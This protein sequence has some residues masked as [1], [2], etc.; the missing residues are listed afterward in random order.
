MVDEMP[1]CGWQITPVCDAAEWD[2]FSAEVRQAATDYAAMI[3]WAAT[4]RRYGVCETTVRP[5]RRDCEDCADGW[6]W[7]DG[8]WLPYIAN[9]VWRNCWCG[10]G[11][12]CQSCRASCQVWLPGPVFAITNVTIDG[13]TVD[14]ST[15]DLQAQDGA[16]WLVRLRPS[17]SSTNCWP[18]HQNFDRALG[19]TDTWS[20]TYE[21]GVPVPS[22]V[23]GAAG[24]LA[25][26]WARGCTGAACRLPG[27]IQNL[28]RQGITVTMAS[29]DEL[30][31]LGLTGL[32][33]VDQVITA[34]NP[35][36]LKSR[37]RISSVELI[38]R[39]RYPM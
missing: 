7:A 30:L 35:Y 1:P 15:Y 26:E 36:G 12:G 29:V 13:T 32:P 6:F 37:P 9:G 4:G 27:R 22:A 23:M 2:A 16:W 39:V 10:T 8:G 14:S 28:T 38:N 34:V 24:I 31:R 19:S 20:V 21:K 5:C 11:A 17:D 3:M 33:E 25:L 18:E